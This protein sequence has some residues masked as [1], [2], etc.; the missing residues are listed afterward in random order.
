MPRL[1]RARDRLDSLSR[2]KI[3]LCDGSERGPKPSKSATEALKTS[4]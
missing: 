2:V 1:F 3:H 4:L